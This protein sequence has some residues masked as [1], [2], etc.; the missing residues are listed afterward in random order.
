MD[1]G[2]SGSGNHN[3]IRIEESRLRRS[4]K[5][6]RMKD[7]LVPVYK[8]KPGGGPG[9][10]GYNLRRGLEI[11]GD[12]KIA[13]VD[14]MDYAGD[15][16]GR[17]ISP[18]NNKSV[19]VRTLKSIIGYDNYLMLGIKYVIPGIV[20]RFIESGIIEQSGCSMI[21]CHDMYFALYL[22]EYL[23]KLGLYRLCTPHAPLSVAVSRGAGKR[24]KFRVDGS[25]YR[26]CLI[27]PRFLNIEK[28]FFAKTDALVLSSEH[29]LD[30]YSEFIDG[31]D[32]IISG[33]KFL[34][35]YFGIPEPVAS[36]N[37]A[38]QCREKLNLPDNKLVVSFT[39]GYHLDK[40][41]DIFLDM[42]SRTKKEN[43]LFACSGRGYINPPEYHN[44]VN[45]GWLDNQYDL[46]SA[47]DVIVV[48]NRYTFF[49]VIILESMALGKPLVLTERGGNKEFR[50]MSEGIKVVKADCNSISRAVDDICLLSKQ[51]REYLG[52]I[53]RGLYEKHFT[54]ER[55]AA[56]YKS[57]IAS[58][59]ISRKEKEYQP[60]LNGILK[61]ER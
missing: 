55:F 19:L 44:L 43:I 18:A 28:N 58:V 12:T 2:C 10:Y 61:A 20:E 14:Y 16:K 45:F 22:D 56:A 54:L 3:T 13:V 50:G 36:F 49:D 47:S 17:F 57:A 9:V 27:H 31:F 29:C 4:G 52:A 46:I 48:A 60:D 37:T 42:V 7:C 51:D 40:G 1:A 30:G 35:V 6:M 39:G 41:F 15:K 23:E 26:D 59:P 33:K 8:I 11:A 32:N 5:G 38:R 21:H 53:N 34:K 24:G 25:V